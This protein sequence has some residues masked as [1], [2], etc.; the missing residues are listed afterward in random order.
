MILN[1]N[2]FVQDEYYKPF[3]VDSTV[4]T[5]ALR[6]E[7]DYDDLATSSGLGFADPALGATRRAAFEDAVR[8]VGDTLRPSR[9]ATVR[10]RVEKSVVQNS[11][12]LAAAQTG[13]PPSGPA[14]LAG[15]L[16]THIQSGI[17]PDPAAPDMNVEFNFYH[18]YHLASSNPPAGTT[19]LR[20]V[21]V[22]EVGHALGLASLLAADG[23]SRRSGTNPGLFT[24]YDA[25]LV[26]AGGTTVMA[27]G[28][29][30]IGSPADLVGAN[31]GEMRW[32]GV[33]ANGELARAPLVY[34]P[35]TFAPGS[36]I[37]HFSYTEGN[38]VMQAGIPPGV[39]RRQFDAFEIAA[40]RDLGYANARAPDDGLL[41][42]G[43]RVAFAAADNP[44]STLITP[45]DD[46]PGLD[47][48]VL[49]NAPGGSALRVY[50]GITAAG[51]R[52]Q[53]YPL[54][55]SYLRMAPARVGPTLAAGIVLSEFSEGSLLALGGLRLPATRLVLEPADFAHLHRVTGSPLPVQRAYFGNPHVAV[56][57]M[58]DDGNMDAVTISQ[59]Q[60]PITF[61]GDGNGHFDRLITPR[62][63]PDLVQANPALDLNAFTDAFVAGRPRMA[64]EV[65]YGLT[66][67]GGEIAAVNPV[68]G[69]QRRTVLANPT[70]GYR[71]TELARFSTGGYAALQ[72]SAPGDTLFARL[73]LE[74]NG[75]FRATTL[76]SYPQITDIALAS[77]P[78][79]PAITSFWFT[80]GT[81]HTVEMLANG[82]AMP[83]TAAGSTRGYRD[84]AAAQAQFD[85]PTAIC[86]GR[87]AIYVADYG[88]AVIRRIDYFNRAVTTVAG[89]PGQRTL[90]DGPRGQGSFNF[91]GADPGSCAVIGDSL[92]VLDGHNPS[93]MVV[94]KVNLANG[95][96]S[97]LADPG[98]PGLANP[99]G[100]Q[101][102]DSALHVLHWSGTTIAI[103]SANAFPFPA[104]PISGMVPHPADVDGDGRLDLLVPLL[105]PFWAINYLRATGDGGYQF[106]AQ[107]VFDQAPN[108]LE[109]RDM[110]G[111]GR[112]DMIAG[113]AGS[114]RVLNQSNGRFF[115]DISSRV[116]TPN[117]RWMQLVD[118][119]F[120]GRPDLAWSDIRGDLRIVLANEAGRWI[121]DGPGQQGE[122]YR[123]RLGVANPRWFSLSDIDNDRDFE[124]L[125]LPEIGNEVSFFEGLPAP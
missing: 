102:W 112:I 93:S 43:P 90:R 114:V 80:T 104:Q 32:L 22:H 16:A 57:D 12:T 124:I 23:R 40:L 42:F 115:E 84:G 122:H 17:D 69:A 38:A 79:D 98:F 88:N 70:P 51:G 78:D 109:T 65:S 35:A 14:F 75:S 87:G 81:G 37:S 67:T 108:T 27:P 15:H 30:F 6:W 96:V 9:P 89:V 119:N 113:L 3:S 58:N 60:G 105:S 39:R 18:T 4:V 5:G 11:P 36:S 99:K 53:V 54:D 28:G 50:S 64:L 48:L 77:Y 41:A 20:S 103:E 94:R 8:I 95:Y 61:F 76:R 46:K 55:A 86:T 83:Q 45:F 100:L 52:S 29:R 21:A 1:E 49:E 91:I 7:I 68:T 121:A 25:L 26:A 47:L 19:D 66:Y 73:T 71:I 97:T 63:Y 92:Y 24:T 117:A 107:T 123:K 125:V 110:D 82:A 116:A 56:A 85:N 106:T 101:A 34:T 59:R 33:Q 72:P 111:D 44:N 62:R 13:F 2:G 74:A 118:A 120:D 31:G 10:V